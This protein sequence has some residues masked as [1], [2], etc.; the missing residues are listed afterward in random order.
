MISLRVLLLGPEEGRLSR[1][2]ARR[3]PA[4]EARAAGNRPHGAG[5]DDLPYEISEDRCMAR[6][7][8][9]QQHSFLP[10]FQARSHG[11]PA[12]EATTQQRRKGRVTESRR[13]LTSIEPFGIELLEVLR[14]TLVLLAPQE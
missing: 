4:R 9:P 1:A 14:P 13:L 10:C 6:I 7:G 5:R 11:A 3:G 12:G 2:E 8:L